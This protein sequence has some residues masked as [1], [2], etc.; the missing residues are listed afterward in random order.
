MVVSNKIPRRGIVIDEDLPPPDKKV[1]TEVYF[2][3][4]VDPVLY[5]PKYNEFSYGVGY[6]MGWQGFKPTLSD[7]LTH[8]LYVKKGLNKFI[9][10]APYIQFNNQHILMGNEVYVATPF[11]P[12]TLDAALKKTA[13]VSRLGG[14]SRA[15]FLT[16]PLY[17]DPKAFFKLLSFGVSTSVRTPRFIPFGVARPV[18]H[19]NLLVQ[20]ATSLSYQFSYLFSGTIQFSETKSLLGNTDG[21]VWQF[22]TVFQRKL[23]YGFGISASYLKSIGKEV[24]EPHLITFKVSWS[25][26]DGLS[27]SGMFKQT[28]GTKDVQVDGTYQKDF[29][30]DKLSTS[31]TFHKSLEKQSVASAIRYNN[32]NGTISYV[33][34]ALQKDQQFGYVFTNQRLNSNIGFIN[35]SI[36]GVPVNVFSLSAESSIVFADGRFALSTPVQDSFVVFSGDNSVKGKTVFV[37]DEGRQIDGFGPTVLP[38]IR[39]RVVTDVV[40]DIPSLSVGSEY[41]R[42]HS[43]QPINVQGYLVEMHVTPSVLLMAKLVSKGRPKKYLRGYILSATDPSMKVKFI[44]SRSGIFQAPNL[45]PGQYQITFGKK[46]FESIDIEIPEDAEGLFKLGKLKV[47]KKKGGRKAGSLPLLSYRNKQKKREQAGGSGSTSFKIDLL[48]N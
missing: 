40:A 30:E 15:S 11:G 34:T 43:F 5:D 46:P 12:I 26:L 18:I 33:D 1:E 41:K 38:S 35:R 31:T 20:Y 6:P 37:G 2:P 36:E 17:N 39:D 44:T 42:L 21:D 13:A 32:H 7:Q 4:A 23:P 22:S 28:V 14:Y 48:H 27:T 16:Y 45:N 10:A 25:G 47:T 9:T 29:M 8:S 19:E 3:F 24:V